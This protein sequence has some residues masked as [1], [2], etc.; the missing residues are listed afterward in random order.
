M[1]RKKYPLTIK[2]IVKGYFMIQDIASIIKEFPQLESDLLWEE[3]G[4]LY[5]DDISHDEIGT[6]VLGSEVGNLICKNQKLVESVLRIIQ[7]GIDFKSS[8]AERMIIDNV[9]ET[10]VEKQHLLMLLKKGIENICRKQS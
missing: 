6:I 7:D 3:Y 5:D 8:L 10:I 2:L 4:Y 9:K 1:K